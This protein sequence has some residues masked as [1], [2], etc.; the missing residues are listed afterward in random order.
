MSPEE[1]KIIY[2]K[3]ED[4]SLERIIRKEI[5]KLPSNVYLFLYEEAI[6]RNFSED[7]ILIV[8]KK[9]N[10][11]KI[12]VSEV[13]RKEEKKSTANKPLVDN[14]QGRFINNIE[15]RYNRGEISLKE[16]SE[17]REFYNYA[18]IDVKRKLDAMEIEVDV[19]DE[20]VVE[21]NSKEKE[22]NTSD[23]I[24]K[25][26][27]L[28]ELLNSGVIN[29]DEYQNLKSGLIEPK[30]KRQ[31][32]S[33]FVELKD[34]LNSGAISELEFEDLKNELNTGTNSKSKKKE[35]KPSH[36]N[37]LNKERIILEPFYDIN[38]KLMKAPNIQFINYNNISD[39]ERKLL[40]DFLRKKQINSP[41][42]MSNDEI[43]LGNK[44]F[45]VNEIHEMNS[46][47]AGYNY[48]W[49]SILSLIAVGLCAFLLYISPCFILFYAGT[50]LLYG[51]GSAIY[52][53]TRADSTKLDKRTSWTSVI[54]AIFIV[55]F[56]FTN[57]YGSEN[58]GS[59]SSDC[60][61]PSQYQSGYASGK[62]ARILGGGSC[63]SY[64]RA[65]NENVGRNLLIADDCFC[66]GYKDGKSGKEERIFFN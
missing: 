38:E 50:G 27:E 20:G 37:Y 43:N 57:D 23:K 29:R 41:E 18:S 63:R 10:D 15:S 12:E 55:V 33:K 16:M 60:D 36:L 42:T 54:L 28:S 53:L 4:K 34:L 32:N 24:Q 62:T 35:S 66:E 9:L 40:R 21:R 30:A 65:Y 3:L 59:S 46:E 13:L 56:M 39:S 8:T 49:T 48:P 19:S 31:D 14:N 5:D 1:I 64:V 44:L 47:Q 58:S 25:L 2:S 11:A 45:T 52:V 51:T 6:K 7:L 17:Y 22:K 61:N 26:K